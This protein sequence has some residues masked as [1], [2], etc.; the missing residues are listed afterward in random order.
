MKS[1]FLSLLMLSSVKA[2]HS[3]NSIDSDNADCQSVYTTSS[4]DDSSDRETTQTPGL[5]FTFDPAY[6]VNPDTFQSLP[7]LG[8]THPV[9]IRH[10]TAQ[11]RIMYPDLLE[12]PRTVNSEPSPA[13]REIIPSLDEE[14]MLQ[15]TIPDAEEIEAKVRN[16]YRH[17]VIKG[18]PNLNTV[19]LVAKHL[20]AGKDDFEIAEL[21]AL[22]AQN[23]RHYRQELKRLGVLE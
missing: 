6:A 20:L 19:I 9:I 10:V 16:K 17:M 7:A 12:F 11:T 21:L 4:N 23:V 5:P 2:S 13:Q 18:R 22:N 1:V 15:R 8:Q 3:I 14:I